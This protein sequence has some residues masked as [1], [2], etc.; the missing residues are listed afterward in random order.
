MEWKRG[1]PEKRNKDQTTWS[2]DDWRNHAADRLC[3]TIYYSNSKV[4]PAAYTHGRQWYWTHKGERVVDNNMAT[5]VDIVNQESLV[6]LCTSSNI[7]HSLINWKH[8]GEVISHFTQT[9]LMKK[10]R[11]FRIFDRGWLHGCM[12]A[13]GLYGPVP[14]FV[15]QD[16]FSQRSTRWLEWNIVFY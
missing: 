9:P 1:H 11:L 15:S 8:T 16:R 13:K 5:F 2:K 14:D 3:D 6:N 7:D 10:S 4:S 12:L